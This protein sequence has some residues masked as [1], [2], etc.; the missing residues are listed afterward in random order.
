MFVYNWVWYLQGN[1]TF[2]F[3]F[4]GQNDLYVLYQAAQL[5]AKEIK[6]E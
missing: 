6:I 4:T 5:Q 2:T 1:M 3:F